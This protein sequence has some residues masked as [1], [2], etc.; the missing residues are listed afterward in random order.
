MTPTK[1]Q[2]IEHLANLKK[3]I[4]K[5]EAIVNAPEKPN[6]REWL[7]NYMNENDGGFQV[8]V[9]KDY[10]WYYRDGQWIFRQD[11]KNKEL[12]CYYYK[13][14]QVFESEY[15]MKREDIQELIKGVVGEALNCKEFT[16]HWNLLILQ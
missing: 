15:S 1:E 7:I 11:L 9:K 10:I 3:E 8:K 16:P 5:Y 2:A 12:D 4:E 14:W 6:A 13:F